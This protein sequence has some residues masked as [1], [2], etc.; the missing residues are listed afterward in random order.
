MDISE[1]SKKSGVPASTLRYYEEL[2]LVTSVGRRGLRRVFEPVVLT[3]LAL[4]ALGRASGFSLKE[5]GQML[6]GEGVPR[7]AP[8]RLLAKATELDQQIARLTAMRDGLRHAA[9][10]PAPSHMECPKFQRIVAVALAGRLQ[11]NHLVHIKPR[12]EH[13]RRYPPV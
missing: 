7:I 1:V 3:R 8:E 10:C 2:G 5:I 11:P 12:L 6:G 4:I 13:Q 9:N